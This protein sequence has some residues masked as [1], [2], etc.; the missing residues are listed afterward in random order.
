LAR[1][2]EVGSGATQRMFIISRSPLTPLK[3][4]GIGVKVLKKEDLG[5]SKDF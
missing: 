1:K 3:K 4:G 2:E 5:G